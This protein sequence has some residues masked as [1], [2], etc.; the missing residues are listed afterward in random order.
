MPASSIS[1]TTAIS[2]LGTARNNYPL[3]L[4][5]KG[6]QGIRCRPFL[7]IGPFTFR[8]PRSVAD[9]RIQ[10]LNCGDR[11]GGKE[12]VLNFQGILLCVYLIEHI[13]H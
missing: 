2:A 13:V 5:K 9:S 6:R 12:N 11:Q 8:E 4:I 7:L 3:R 1:I 10:E